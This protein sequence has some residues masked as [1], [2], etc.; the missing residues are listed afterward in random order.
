M[1]RFGA[2]RAR[3]VFQAD[4]RGLMCALPW[5]LFKALASRVKKYT[6]GSDRR[7]RMELGVKYR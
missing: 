6:H 3:L 5:S 2:S 4:S 1:W 7:H